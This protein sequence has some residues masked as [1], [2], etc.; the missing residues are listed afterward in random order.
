MTSAFFRLT[1]ETCF[2][3]AGLAPWASVPHVLNVPAPSSLTLHCLFSSLGYSGVY[4]KYPPEI[5]SLLFNQS[6]PTHPGGLSQIIPHV[7]NL[8][9]GCPLW[10]WFPLWNAITALNRLSCYPLEDWD[11]VSSLE[12]N[13]GSSLQTEEE[14]GL[15]WG[16]PMAGLHRVRHDKQLRTRAHQY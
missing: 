3:M 7:W 4:D 8:S 2:V 15:P 1:P 14:A 16:H 10:L 5:P 12:S 6:N 11:D 9:S 13:P